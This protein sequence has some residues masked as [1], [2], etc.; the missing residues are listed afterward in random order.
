ML[1]IAIMDSDAYIKNGVAHYFKSDMTRI[2]STSNI[3][4]LTINLQYDEMDVVM[5]EL[6]SRDDSIFDCIEF[7]RNF[8]AR[9]PNS[10][11][12]VYTQIMNAETTKLLES[13]TGQKDIVFKN[14]PITR[15]VEC[16]FSPWKGNVLQYSMVG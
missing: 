2:M 13:V 1:N 4:D 11:L 9:W 3:G 5:M 10:K 16:V 12:V 15:L 8:P 6:F 7:I 14:N